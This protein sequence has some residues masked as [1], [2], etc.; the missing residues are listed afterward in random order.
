[1]TRHL[2]SHIEQNR[3]QMTRTIK[4][5]TALPYAQ[6]KVWQA[7][8]DPQLLGNWFMGKQY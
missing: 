5:K 7:L 2:Q 6:D 3:Q 1:M 8:T 4:L